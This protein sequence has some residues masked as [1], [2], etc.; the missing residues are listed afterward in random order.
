MNVAEVVFRD[1]KECQ[2]KGEHVVFLDLCDTVVLV[3]REKYMN[4]DSKRGREGKSESER[5]EELD[6]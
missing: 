5:G 6:R 3:M 2:A 1:V 4:V